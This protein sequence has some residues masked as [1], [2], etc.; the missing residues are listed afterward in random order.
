[1][2]CPFPPRKADFGKS[3]VVFYWKLGNLLVAFLRLGL[4][5]KLFGCFGEGDASGCFCFWFS[6]C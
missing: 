6:V 1:M 5:R 4:G 3:L 2:T